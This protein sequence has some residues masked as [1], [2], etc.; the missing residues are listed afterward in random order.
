LF[1][2]RIQMM[3]LYLEGFLSRPHGE[4]LVSARVVLGGTMVVLE[5]AT[6]ALDARASPDVVDV[7]DPAADVVA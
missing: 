2:S 5:G 3:C 1:S 6:V 4:L 7:R